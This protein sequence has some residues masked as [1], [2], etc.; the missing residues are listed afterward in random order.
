MRVITSILSKQF[1]RLALIGC[2][3]VLLFLCSLVIVPV[4]SQSV[5]PVRDN[6]HA[7]AH[8]DQSVIVI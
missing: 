8:S 1:R 3:L 5:T 6:T 4:R 7:I 2:S